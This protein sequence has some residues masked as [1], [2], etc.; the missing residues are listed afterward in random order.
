MLLE[1]AAKHDLVCY[2]P[3]WP[4][5][6]YPPRIAAMPHLRLT[7]ENWT[8]IDNP[9]PDQIARTLEALNVADNSFAILEITDTTYLQAALQAHGSYIVEYQ[10]GSVDQH[11][12]AT[13]TDLTSLASMFSDYADSNEQW[14]SQRTWKRLIL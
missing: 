11:F 1:I 12:Q 7:T 5:V 2:N 8:L 10:E 4:G 9:T 3:Q 6:T 14:K 13:V